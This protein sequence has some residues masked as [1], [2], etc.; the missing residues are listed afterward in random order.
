MKYDQG[1]LRMGLC[2]NQFS[3]GLVGV[4][5]VLT[6]GAWKYP[7]QES[8]DCSWRLVDNAVERY[9]DAFDR[10]MTEVRGDMTAFIDG[11][12]GREVAI[13]KDSGLLH[14]DHAITNLFFLRSLMYGDKVDLDIIHPKQEASTVS[15]APTQ[16]T[17]NQTDISCP[18]FH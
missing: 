15:E 3:N 18:R 11:V 6:F 1:K 12:K 2:F 9:G 13:A 7:H 8:H 5:K 14:I 16:D 10:H 17:S 4:V